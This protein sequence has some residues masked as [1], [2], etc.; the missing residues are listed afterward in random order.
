[1]QDMQGLNGASETQGRMTL[2][3]Y[4]CAANDAVA[5]F[6]ATGIPICPTS[7]M[8]ISVGSDCTEPPNLAP[9]TDLTNCDLSGANLSH[10]KLGGANLSFANLGGA[11][12]SG[13]FLGGANLSGANLKIADLTG[14]NLKSANLNRV[15]WFN[16]TCPDGTN[17][18]DLDGDGFTC[19]SNL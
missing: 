10:T 3:A 6:D 8:A 12:L 18:D 11:N 4:N 9:Y 14:A 16:T 5:A 2:A 15:L 17:S 19:L 13:A 1:M 7:G